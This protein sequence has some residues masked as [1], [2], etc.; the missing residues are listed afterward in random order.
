MRLI[1]VFNCKGQDKGV[2]VFDMSDLID[3][4][5]VKTAG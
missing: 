2:L 5:A 1:A 4:Q 3:L